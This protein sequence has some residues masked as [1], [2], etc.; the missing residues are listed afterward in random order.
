[1]PDAPRPA[2]A[3]V[4]PRDP[5]AQLVALQQGLGNRAVQSRLGGCP[6]L[7]ACPT[8][9]ACH[10]C[11]FRGP[12]AVSPAPAGLQPKLVVGPPGDRYEQQADRVA[13]Q[14]VDGPA[15]MAGEIQQSSGAMLQRA[16]SGCGPDDEPR[17][18]RAPTAGATGDAPVH[19]AE[20]GRAATFVPPSGA[21][22]PLP[23]ASREYFE[24]RFGYGLGD[25]RVHTDAAADASAR[26]VRARAYTVGRDIAFAAGQY[27]PETGEGRR[28]LAH[29]LTHV[30]QQ[31][32][33]G[34][35]PV[36]QRQPQPGQPQ[37][38]PARPQGPTFFGPLAGQ[39]PADWSARVNAAADSAARAA[40]L[41]EATGM[42]VEDRTAASSGDA[43]PTAAHLVE[44][45][46]ASPRINYDDGLNLKRSP[47]G[48]ER[49]ETHRLLRENAGYTLTMSGRQYIVL[50]PRALDADRYFWSRVVLNHE[51]D[52]IR[53]HQAH[54][55]LTGN[56]SEVDAWTSTLI[57]EFHRNYILGELPS[58]CYIQQISDFRPLLFYYT[59]PDVTDVVRNDAVSRISDYYRSTIAPHPGHLRAF[60]Y[61]I[62]RSMRGGPTIA[63]LAERL[64]T[65]LVLGVD[66]NA[67]AATV[68][69]FPCADV[70]GAAYPAPPTVVPPGGPSG[71]TATPPT[72][73]ATTP[74][75]RASAAGPGEEGLPARRFG[76]ELTGGVGFT[77]STGALG[78]AV[79]LGARFALRSDRLIVFNPLIGAHLVYLP[80]TGSNADHVAAAIGEVGL[81]IQQPLQGVYVDVRAGGFVGLSV[82]TAT[83]P[84]ATGP[85]AGGPSFE[86]GATGQVGIGYRW[87]RV[88][89]GASAR[90]MFELGAGPD[91]VI[92][93]G[94]GA[95]SF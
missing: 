23:P 58:T 87:E 5:T 56:N 75:S 33:V 11:P 79:D 28:L 71:G 40:L 14:V 37:P 90:G 76:L 82:P 74:G 1:L 19:A 66:L 86:R 2:S 59:Q 53:Q 15:A 88:E 80:P 45:T 84:G 55:A 41:T 16:C 67:A 29:E 50:G 94:G 51:F 65:D 52:H 81:R 91:R 25:V 57:R 61:W 78:A 85:T 31:G 20:A 95:V 3:A 8:G 48:G 46:A 43:V 89:L 42:T 26:A 63:P 18:Q 9:G 44:L 73:G 70:R 17:V 12:P 38:Q 6:A 49:I 13:E 60:R 35:A 7:A 22:R 27:A 10:S 72:T 4:G 77:P 62:Y 54:S 64:N 39:G 34:M 32:A 30:V 68:R 69:Q 36:V 93:L 92:V 24:P 47:F 83:G 21:G